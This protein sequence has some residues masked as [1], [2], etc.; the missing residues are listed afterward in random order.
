LAIGGHE[1]FKRS[2]DHF[3]ELSLSFFEY[4]VVTRYD[5]GESAA[6]QVYDQPFST[7]SGSETL[8]NV[9][10]FRRR[11]LQMAYVVG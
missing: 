9:R 6:S 11:D 4:F 10:G 5:T 3:F 1:L 7:F 2:E 8:A